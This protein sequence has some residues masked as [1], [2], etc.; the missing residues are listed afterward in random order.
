[1]LYGFWN[2]YGC[3]VCNMFPPWKLG[4]LKHTEGSSR[5]CFSVKGR[6]EVYSFS[7][8]IIPGRSRLACNYRSVNAA[9]SSQQSVSASSSCFMTPGKQ[10]DCCCKHSLTQLTKAPGRMRERRRTLYESTTSHVV[11]SQMGLTINWSLYGGLPLLDVNKD[12]DVQFLVI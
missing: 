1:M 7:K 6:T 3:N 10:P 4:F 12:T 9:N 11:T 2:A 8:H 5:P